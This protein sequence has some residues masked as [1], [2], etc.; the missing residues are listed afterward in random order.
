MSVVGVEKLYDIEHRAHFVWEENRE[1]LHQRSTNFRG[2][3]GEIE[4]HNVGEARAGDYLPAGQANANHYCGDSG[5]RVCLSRADLS[6]W[7]ERSERSSDSLRIGLASAK[8]SQAQPHDKVKPAPP[9][10]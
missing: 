6:G 1:L 5:E 3:F 7:P 8:T 2:G 4:S 9:C 10:P